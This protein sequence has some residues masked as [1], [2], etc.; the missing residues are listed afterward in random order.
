MDQH[1]RLEQPER[2]AAAAGA[3]DGPADDR[4]EAL[5]AVAPRGLAGGQRRVVAGVLAQLVDHP[6]GQVDG[7]VE[8]E[9][10]LDDPLDPTTQRSPRRTWASSWSRTQFNC[11]GVR[12][13]SRSGGITTV[14]RTSPPTAGE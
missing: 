6:V 4:Q 11:L 8:E 9:D 14:G 1:P 10:R 7:R 2:R 12:P 13:S 5:A 3:L